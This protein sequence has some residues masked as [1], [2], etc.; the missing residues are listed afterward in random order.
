MTWTQDCSGP[1]TKI[2]ASSYSFV[3]LAFRLAV[4]LLT[5]A[6]ALRPKLGLAWFLGQYIHK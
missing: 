4:G 2:M 3:I 5:A 1:E 6:S